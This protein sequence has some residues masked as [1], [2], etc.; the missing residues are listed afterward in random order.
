[1]HSSTQHT[2]AQPFPFCPC[3]MLTSSAVRAFVLADVLFSYLTSHNCKLNQQDPTPQRPNTSAPRADRRYSHSVFV[4]CAWQMISITTR[5]T[6][7]AP[8]ATSAWRC[9]TVRFPPRTPRGLLHQLSCHRHLTT[10]S[11]CVVL[12][13]VSMYAISQKEG[14]VAI[15]EPSRS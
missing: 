2:H 13:E 9:S 1:M 8:S 12:A 10:F 14:C 4:H 3:T 15:A 5:R 11:G 6:T 7:C